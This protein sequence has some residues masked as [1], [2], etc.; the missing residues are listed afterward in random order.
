MHREKLQ[1]ERSPSVVSGGRENKPGNVK[2]CVSSGEAQLPGGCQV[3]A[4]SADQRRRS[5]P[6]E[7]EGGAV[8]SWAALPGGRVPDPVQSQSEYENPVMSK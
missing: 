8:E 5:R 4:V 7:R 6:R 1:T 3:A 2:Q